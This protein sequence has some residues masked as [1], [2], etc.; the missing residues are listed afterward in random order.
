VSTQPQTRSTPTSTETTATQQQ[1]SLFNPVEAARKAAEAAKKQAPQLP[2]EI[3]AKL[4]Q[5]DKIKEAQANYIEF[6]NGDEKI[7]YVDPA[8]MN[9]TENKLTRKR[10]L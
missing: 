9:I 8:K 1:T 4:D 5:I 3:L 2:A 6:D 7:L 10:A